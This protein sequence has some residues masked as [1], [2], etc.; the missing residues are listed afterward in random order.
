MKTRLKK[1]LFL[2]CQNSFEAYSMTK[3][4]SHLENAGIAEKKN[5]KAIGWKEKS[6]PRQ[7]SGQIKIHPDFVPTNAIKFL[8]CFKNCF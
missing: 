1:L 7:D 4:I 2:R 5:W 3:K 8:R 6:N